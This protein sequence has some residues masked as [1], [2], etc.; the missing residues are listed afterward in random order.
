MKDRVK[1]LVSELDEAVKN[2]RQEP[3]EGHSWPWEDEHVAGL[4]LADAAEALILALPT[5]TW[6]ASWFE[7]ESRAPRTPLSNYEKQL[8]SELID[9]LNL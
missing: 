6:P 4:N 3:E 7:E 8:V 2:M 5:D 1:H 9:R